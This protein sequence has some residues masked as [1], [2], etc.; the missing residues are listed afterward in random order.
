[1]S[2][3]ILPAKAILRQL[4]SR[5]QQLRLRRGLTRAAFSA[6]CG[7]PEATI[8]RFESTGEIGTKA[9]VNIFM[10]LDVVEQ[11]AG[12]AKAIEPATMDEVL[13]Q[14]RQRGRRSDAGQPRAASKEEK[15]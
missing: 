9:M 5:V 14:R 7:V 10:S 3:S 6:L 12:L 11:F 15:S 8:K 13:Q 4:G 1:M 2:L